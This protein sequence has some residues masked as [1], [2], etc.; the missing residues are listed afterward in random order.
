MTTTSKAQFV[1]DTNRESV[2]GD[3]EY[4]IRP[5]ITNNGVGRFTL[6]NRNGSCPLHVGLENTHFSQHSLHVKFIPFA[7]HHD[8]DD[9]RLN[10]DLRVIFQARHKEWKKVDYNWKR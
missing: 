6:V 10:R 2:E 5:I 9:V 7:P 1:L 3:E 8:D 4:F